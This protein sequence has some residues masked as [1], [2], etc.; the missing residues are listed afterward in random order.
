VFQSDLLNVR[1]WE[2]FLARISRTIGIN[3]YLIY[4]L[5][6]RWAAGARVEW[7]Q[8]NLFDGVGGPV[9]AG[10][11]YVSYNAATFGLNYRPHPNLVLR[12]EVKH[13]WV[14]AEA[15]EQTIFGIDMVLTY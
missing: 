10:Q 15:F 14:P 2:A 12:P 3:Q 6:D 7:W 4:E 13:E 9:A 8:N 11:P 1:D 5:N